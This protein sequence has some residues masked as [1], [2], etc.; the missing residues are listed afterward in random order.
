MLLQEIKCVADDFPAIGIRLARLP[1]RDPRTEGLNGVALLSRFPPA[2]VI[3]RL[4][5]DDSD[6]HARY[7]RGGGL[8]RD[9]A[10]G[11]SLY[12]PNGN[13]VDTR[14]V[15]VQHG[16]VARLAAMPASGY[17]RR[18]LVLAG[19]YN[20][21]PEDVT[22]ASGAW[23]ATRCSAA[24]ASAFRALVDLG[25]IDG[26]R[27]VD[28][29]VAPLYVLGLSGRRW[30]HDNGIRIDH[31]LLSPEAADGLTDG[32]YRSPRA[33]L[34]ETVQHVPVWLDL[35]IEAQNKR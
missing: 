23:V 20:V 30:Q 13:P 35:A 19:D 34:G 27:A 6:Y 32:R 9:A 18:P 5:G 25:L 31:L 17:P 10:S 21:I 3:T 29:R 33:H 2:D 16:L 12:L 4:P 22:H 1:P 24:D 7:H 28:G 14:E 15:C 8:Y 11:R 26:V